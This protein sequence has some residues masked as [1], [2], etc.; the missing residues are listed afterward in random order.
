[1][2]DEE[3]CERVIGNLGS[4]Y[5][6]CNRRSYEKPWTNNINIMA[7]FE[8]GFKNQI[9][10]LGRNAW[11]GGQ[12]FRRLLRYRL[13]QTSV[14]LTVLEYFTSSTRS[15]EKDLPIRRF[16]RPTQDTLQEVILCWRI[17][18]CYHKR[19][20]LQNDR[21]NRSGAFKDGKRSNRTVL[22]QNSKDIRYQIKPHPQTGEIIA[23]KGEEISEDVAE[24]IVA[25]GITTLVLRTVL[26]CKSKHGVCVTCYGRNLAT[27]K[28]VNVGE[29]VGIIA[30]QSI[31]ES[32]AA[33]MRTFHMRRSCGWRHHAGS[34]KG[35]GAEARKPKGLS[36]ITEVA[37]TVKFVENGKRKDII[38]TTESGEEN[39]YQIPY[40]AMLKVRDGQ[41]VKPG[42]CLLRSINPHDILRLTA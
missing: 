9:R 12:C 6:P 31:G 13:N 14:S 36:V 28:N 24:A 27:G 8:Q 25:A 18:G 34:S 16:V 20:R 33:T 38:V 15:Q 19:D 30:A 41:Y 21:R 35:W 42:E 23:R 22:W 40:G 39:E 37:G 4:Y 10:Q 29:A 5:W 32:N 3:I 11:D 26:N 17:S 2:S 1:M 7:V